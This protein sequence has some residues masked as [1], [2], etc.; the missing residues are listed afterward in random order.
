M[1]MWLTRPSLLMLAASPWFLVFS[2]ALAFFK[3][4]LTQIVW[5]VGETVLCVPLLLL[6]SGRPLERRFAPV[7]RAVPQIEVD[8]LLIG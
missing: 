1:T 3:S 5:L 8:E 6:S 4:P 2:L 7:D